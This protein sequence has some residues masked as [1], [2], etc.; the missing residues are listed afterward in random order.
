M[1]LNDLKHINQS[2]MIELA[3]RIKKDARTNPTYIYT[4]EDIAKSKHPSKECLV[5]GQLGCDR[6]YLK[7]YLH[8]A[9]LRQLLREKNKLM[10]SVNR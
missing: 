3:E 2:K 5:C 10:Q 4:K 7:Y 8:K 9:C 1:S 6:A